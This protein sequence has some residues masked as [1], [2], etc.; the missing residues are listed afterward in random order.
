[1]LVLSDQLGTEKEKYFLIMAM[2]RDRVIV[3][4][5]TFDFIAVRSIVVVV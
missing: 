5:T 4:N 2:V 1:M 3:F